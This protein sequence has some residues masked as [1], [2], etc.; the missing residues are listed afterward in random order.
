[1]HPSAYP[2]RSLPPTLPMTQFLPIASYH[3]FRPPSTTPLARPVQAGYTTLHLVMALDRPDIID[4]HLALGANIDAKTN[5]V[6]QP[7]HLASFLTP[8]APH[9]STA[10]GLAARRMLAASSSDLQLR[11]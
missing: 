4:S 2:H 1:V 11:S 10:R 9:P 7:P 6:P 3:I 5:A 8:L